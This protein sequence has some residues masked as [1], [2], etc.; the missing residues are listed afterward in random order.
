LGENEDVV[1][2]MS[3]H[4]SKGLEFPVVILAGCGKQFNLMDLNKRILYHEELGYGPDYVDYV[5]R[6]TFPTIKKMAI[7]KKFR[8]ESLSEEM[9]IL[10]V[11]L[12]RAKEK[13]IITGSV[14]NMEKSA[15]RWCNAANQSGKKVP[16]YEV[17]KGRTYMD[18]IGMAVSRHKDGEII[19]KAADSYVNVTME[20]E[21][22]TW[23]V[24]IW[25]KNDVIVDKK[26]EIV[27]EVPA[28]KDLFINKLTNGEYSE[29]IKRRLDWRYKYIAA[30]AIPANVS[31]SELKRAASEDIDD[32]NVV[33]IYKTQSIRKPK[34]LQEE[35]GLSAAEKGTAVH[36]AMQHLDLDK[37][38]TTGEIETQIET[39]IEKAFITEEQ[40]AVIKPYRILKFFKSPIGQ[41]LL[42]AHKAGTEIHREVAF[43][44]DMPATTID[45]TL[46]KDIYEEE[47]VRLQGVIDGY[48]E[49]EGGVVL[50]DYKTD[51]VGEEVTPEDIKERYKIQIKYY[52]DTLEK[53]MGMPIKD[54]YLYLFYSGDIIEME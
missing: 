34:F 14:G 36:F 51:Y 18:W 25:S 12:T 6:L 3:I 38:N 29:E 23:Q 37:V 30:A 54:K 39:M 31:V 1:R 53:I 41:R 50:F 8:L 9:R 46:P 16:D 28:E 11:A 5:R 10:Y 15:A 42:K 44:I 32:G 24:K 20:D 49:E 45:P 43:Y 52:S 13:L 17:V 2:I 21:L 22:S 19:R 4:K 27:D 33:S 47:M 40:A 26:I 48:F 35:K 7:K